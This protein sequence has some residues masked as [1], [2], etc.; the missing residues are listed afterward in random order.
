M[1]LMFYRL[2]ICSMFYVRVPGYCISTF[3]T[4][5]RPVSWP[6]TAYT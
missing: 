2:P 1:F 6:K 3:T 5:F 4:K